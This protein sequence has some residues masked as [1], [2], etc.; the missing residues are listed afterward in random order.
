MHNRACYFCI[1]Y[2]IRFLDNPVTED[3]LMAIEG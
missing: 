1:G 2:P 3:N